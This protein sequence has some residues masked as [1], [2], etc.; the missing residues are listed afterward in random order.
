VESNFL[1][2]RLKA[3]VPVAALVV[4]ALVAVTTAMTILGDSAPDPTFIIP[5]LSPSPSATPLPTPY[6]P[7]TDTPTPLKTVPVPAKPPVVLTIYH[8]EHD[9]NR[10]WFVVWRYPELRP[11]STPMAAAVNADILDEVQTRI[12]AWENGPAAVQQVPGKT[13]NLTGSF[14]V[15]MN[16]NDLFS[17]T[18]KWVDDTSAAHSA[19]SV[20]T[21]T[22]ALNSGERL[23]FG[24]VFADEQAALT[25]ISS[26]ARTQLS[27]SLGADYDPAAVEQG[28][29]AVGANFNNWALTPSGLRII[30]AEYQVGTYAAGMPTVLIP[31]SSLVTVVAPNGPAARLAGLPPSSSVPTETSTSVPTSAAS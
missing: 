3:L 31:W 1:V 4:V 20:E 9:P 19:T 6:D 18:L 27:K 29:A 23:D 28:T 14:S 22:Y 17:V 8:G 10:V 16:A 25:I 7:P 24:Q 11:G 15:N 13:N 12:E 2:R 5:T 30:F 21:L 26:Q